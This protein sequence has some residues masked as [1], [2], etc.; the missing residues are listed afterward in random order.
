MKYVFS[1]DEK[2]IRKR[3]GKLL[4]QMEPNT[5]V[6]ECG[7]A[8]G[9]L[10]SFLKEKMHCSVYIVEYEQA[11]FD[12]AKKYAAGGICADLMGKEWISYFAGMHFDYILFPDVLEHLMDPLRVVKEAAK[13][14]NEHGKMIVSLPNIGHNDIVLKLLKGEWNYTSQ[15][16]LDDTHIHFWGIN[17]LE[18]FFKQAGL[19]VKVFDATYQPTLHTEQFAGEDH[20]LNGQMIEMICSRREGEIFQFVLTLEKDNG[21]A[22]SNCENMIESVSSRDR[23]LQTLITK[24]FM[25]E[26]SGY[27]EED[28]IEYPFDKTPKRNIQIILP[29][30]VRVIR[31]DPVECMGCVLKHLQITINDEPIDPT[32]TN[33]IRWGEMYV[34]QTDDPQIAI[35][36]PE[37]AEKRKISFC[38]EVY[39]FKEHIVHQVFT[40][41]REALLNELIA[42]KDAESRKDEQERSE[43]NE[44]IAAK[45]AQS[46]ARE[47]EM[48]KLK[49]QLEEVTSML[50]EERRNSESLRDAIES[51]NQRANAVEQAYQQQ[52]NQ[53]FE[54][55]SREQSTVTQLIEENRQLQTSMLETQ[56]AAGEVEAHNRVLIEQLETTR[57]SCEKMASHNDL[58][59]KENTDLHL[60]LQEARA[61]LDAC[62][63]ELNLQIT[64]MQSSFDELAEE[65]H[66]L[67]AN[68]KDAELQLKDLTYSAE[69]LF[70]EKKELM[71]HRADLEARVASATERLTELEKQKNALNCHAQE[72]NQQNEN[73]VIHQG[74]LESYIAELG[75]QLE[76]VQMNAHDLET[77][78][79]ELRNQNEH[80]QNQLTYVSDGYQQMKTNYELISNADFWKMTKPLRSM[81]IAVKQTK[82]G[83]LL[84]K[85]ARSLKNE[86]LKKTVSKTE[87]H[88]FKKKEKGTGQEAPQ[89]TVAAVVMDDGLRCDLRVHKENV[90]VSVIVPNYNHAPYLRERLDSIYQQTYQNFEVILLDDCSKDDSRSILEEYARKYPDRTRTA[91]NQKNV[92]RVNLQWEKGMALAKGD[93]IWIAESDDYCELDFL[94]K[95]IPAFEKESV[96]IAYARSV[97]VKN[98]APCWTL[99]EYLHDLPD[100]DWKNG[101][102]YETAY[103]LVRKGFAVKNII[104]NVSS[105]LF[106]KRDRIPE[107][108]MK[109]WENIRLCGDWLFYLDTIKGGVLYYTSKTTNYYR[110]HDKSTSLD[111]QKTERY[112]IESETISKFA[113]ANYDLDLN[114]F[115]HTRMVLLEHYHLN[116]PNGTEARFNEL[117][118]LERIRKAAAERKPNVMI[119]GFSFSVGGGEIVPIE[120]ANALSKLDVA[121]T[122]VNC[123]YTDTVE[124]VRRK[125]PQHVPVVNV[126]DKIQLIEIAREFGAEVIHTHHA[127]VDQLVAEYVMPTRPQAKHIITLHGMYETINDQTVLNNL[128]TLVT[129]TCDRFVYIADKNLKVFDDHMPIAKERFIKLPNGMPVIESK[130]ADRAALGIPN[131]AFVLCLVSRALFTK[132]W[133]EAVDIVNRANKLSKREIHLVMVGDGEAYD[134]LSKH[135]LSK[136]IHLVGV[137]Q[138]TAQYYKMADMGFLPSRYAGESFPLVVIESLLCGKPVLASNL[139]EI[140]NMLS[141]EGNALAGAV[142][143]LEDMKIPVGEVARMVADIAQNKK[144]YASM[145]KRAPRLASRYDILT[146]ARQYLD[147][148]QGTLKR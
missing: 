127:S 102:F 15:G 25:D 120:L 135:K 99:E 57:S 117:Y 61:Q 130:A 114:V 81:M 34:Y 60:H 39:P 143:E 44:L 85:V 6:L 87:Q 22:D 96:Q 18:S 36:L 68:Q 95:L 86:G 111:V 37:C 107:R 56:K 142:F 55:L 43:L 89:E 23:L 33:G 54:V 59:S 92:G 35:A 115:D 21:E 1:S 67:E 121:V 134:K 138:N 106:R 19:K 91:F 48:N 74:E 140:H 136:Y 64:A 28:S 110:V 103:N 38:C 125:L 112:Y 29:P 126:N 98:G 76:S 13:M 137:Q 144:Y 128:L 80:M 145:K 24:V 16:L 75:K 78:T 77:Q 146:V 10:T 17:N 94:E 79:N 133:L 69:K 5:T 26:G 105:A 104:P 42:I 50:S 62:K 3:F 46:L 90:L 45:D 7:C 71:E 147:V 70:A 129:R 40:E 82:S 27:C 65:K 8:T 49:I 14:L 11:A 12:I 2:D 148:Y 41:H 66:A 53:V 123:R 109:I 31:F 131:D 63:N 84:Y 4:S 124:Q 97:F 116:N 119:C 83:Q 52:A 141:L 101:T 122:F 47:Q 108:I 20:T 139:G 32:Y 93:L 88:I 58:L 51:M 9:Y 73:L 30:T 100:Y 72:L 118:S 113:A 132:G